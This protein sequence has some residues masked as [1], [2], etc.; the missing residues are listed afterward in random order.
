MTFEQ[1]MEA[2]RRADAAG[3]TEDARRLAQIANRLKGQT[4]PRPAQEGFMGQ[5]NRGIANTIGGVVDFVN[6]FDNEVWQGT[7]VGMGS[8]QDGLATGMRAIGARVADEEPTSVGAAIG[9]GVGNAAGALPTVAGGLVAL[10]RQGGAVGAAAREAY[11]VLMTRAGMATEA[12]AGGIS[13]GAAE[14]VQQQGGGELAQNIA[15]LAAPLSLPA[16]AALGRGAV[17]LASRTPTG[18]ALNIAVRAGRNAARSFAPMTEQGAFQVSRER[19][20]ELAGGEDRARELGARVTVG[21]ELGRTPA[22][23]TGDP[24]MLGL[25]RAAAEESPAL[26][27]RLASRATGTRTAARETVTSMGGNVRDARQ[28]FATRQR[29]FSSAIG[30]RIDRVMSGADAQVAGAGP[31]NSEVAN[32]EAMVARLKQELD[33]QKMVEDQKWAA[34]PETVVV[35]PMNA[36]RTAAEFVK[37]LGQSQAGDMPRLARRLLVD[38]KGY[39][40]EISA[41]ELHGL[42]SKLRETARNARAGTKTQPNLARVADKIADAILRDLDS[43]EDTS[44]ELGM[45]LNEARAFSAALHDKFDKGA[46]GRILQRTVDGDE[47]IAPEAALARTVGRGGAQAVADD[48]AITSATPRAGENVTD[49]LR[50]RFS[51]SIVSPTGEFNQSGASAWLRQNRELLSR[52]PGMREEFTRALRSRE[53]AETFAARAAVRE[54]AAASGPVAEFNRGQDQKAVLSILGA[55]NPAQAARSVAA[56]ARKDPTGAAFAGVKGAF[57]D[58]LIGKADTADGLSGR[59]LQALLRDQ[60][61]VAAM[62]QVFPRDEFTRIKRIADELATIEAPAADV[63]EVINSPGNQILQYVVRIAAA[64]Q[65]GQMGGGTM[66]GSLQTANIAVDRAQ[67]ILR[68]LTNARAREMLMAAVED[69]ALFRALLVEPKGY[70]LPPQ[71]ARSLA[72]YIAGGAANVE[73]NEGGQDRRPMRLEMTDPGNQ[74]R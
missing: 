42:Y 52:Y 47:A 20:V 29:E 4:A 63:G 73:G 18:T 57:T 7:P 46:V 40:N 1:A 10:A 8:A 17:N 36:K 6:P 13:E 2:L 9:R 16:T 15:R 70:Q 59:Q 44:S 22:Q 67:A 39:G 62:R 69:P 60:N 30:K 5:V 21:D 71:V 66:G 51:D 53:A 33:A 14:V 55:D 38:E 43:I 56:T 28:F 34:V 12:V 26:R 35:S 48:R 31:R 32:S 19:M 50:G 74:S 41:S 49:Y 23:Q 11:Q 37:S 3:A 58:F 27:D 24:N 68:N 65:G 61:T 45:A 64:R 25:E 54:K 72:P